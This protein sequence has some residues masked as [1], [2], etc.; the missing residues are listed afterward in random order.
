MPEY[1]IVSNQG[2]KHLASLIIFPTRQKAE[3]YKVELVRNNPRTLSNG[4]TLT[5]GEL[6]SK[7]TYTPIIWLADTEIEE[8]GGD[9]E[10]SG[11]IAAKVAGALMELGYWDILKSVI[12]E[13]SH[14]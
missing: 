1:V 9:P 8:Y 6:F 7:D 14:D 2:Q 11:E 5:I 3:E 12:Q 4:D 13:I 10:Y